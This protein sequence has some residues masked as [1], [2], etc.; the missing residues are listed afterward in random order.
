ML[1]KVFTARELPHL[2]ST[3]D[4]R[5]RLD[6]VTDSV[7]AG[8]QLLRADRIIYHPGDTAAGCSRATGALAPISSSNWHFTF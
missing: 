8:A 4:S 1:V 7:P 6:L 5:D 2:I 3:R